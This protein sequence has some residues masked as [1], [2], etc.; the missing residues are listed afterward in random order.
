MDPNDDEHIDVCQNIEVGLKAQYENNPQLTDA[1]CTFALENAKIAIKKEFGYAKNERVTNM[2]EAQGIIQ[3]CVDIG[4]ARIDKINDLTLKE[5]I[6]R[7][8]KIRKS[9]NRHSK[10]GS[11][12]YYEF[13]KKYV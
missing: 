10:Y 9:V 1:Q 11:R 5:Y 8:E 3:W 2:E 4:L 7:I 6:N 13:I 12:G